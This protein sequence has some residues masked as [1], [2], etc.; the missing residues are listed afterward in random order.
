M[1]M[2]NRTVGLGTRVG[3]ESVAGSVP[4]AHVLFLCQMGMTVLLSE[5]AALRPA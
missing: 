5:G 4:W 3:V 1:K 2:N